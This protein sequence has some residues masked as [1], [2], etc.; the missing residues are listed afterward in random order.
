MRSMEKW[1]MR[2]MTC[3][4][5]AFLLQ[6]THMLPVRQRQKCWCT[7]IRNHSS[8]PL[9]SYGVTTSTDHINSPKVS[10]FLCAVMPINQL[11]NPKKSFRNSHVCS[12]AASPWCFTVMDLL[13][14]DTSSLEMLQTHST[15][16]FTRVPLATSTM[17]ARMMRSQT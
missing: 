8:F 12:T 13:L 9:L 1:R 7:H 2:T 11:S 15:R 5:R 16:F 10:P 3:L 14:D 4:R 6:P 17:S